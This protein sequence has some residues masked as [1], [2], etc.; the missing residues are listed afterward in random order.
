MSLTNNSITDLSAL[1]DLTRLRYLYLGGNSISDLSAISGM[2]NL[3]NLYLWSNQLIDVGPL[4]GL[5][6]EAKIGFIDLGQNLMVDLSPLADLRANLLILDSNSVVDVTPL[7]TSTRIGA[8]SLKDN[9]VDCEIY[10]SHRAA[11][12]TNRMSVPTDCPL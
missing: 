12:D 6:A 11:F 2:T 9:P 10:Q 8:V 4:A 7:A 1:S 5:A 3:V